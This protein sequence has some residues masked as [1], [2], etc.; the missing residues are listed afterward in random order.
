[1]GEA[2]NEIRLDA[3]VM[4]R[5]ASWWDKPD[6]WKPKKYHKVDP[7]RVGEFGHPLALCD[8][9]INLDDESECSIKNVPS[10]LLCKRCFR[11]T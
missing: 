5:D 8:K 7:D 10:S 6:T 11:G 9:R 3:L 4:R 1:M 2:K